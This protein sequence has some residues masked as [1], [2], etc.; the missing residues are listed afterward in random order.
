MLSSPPDKSFTDVPLEAESYNLPDST[1]WVQEVASGKNLDFRGVRL[2]AEQY[3]TNVQ[4]IQQMVDGDKYELRDANGLTTPL[5]ENGR[6]L[7][8]SGCHFE[9]VV[10][11]VSFER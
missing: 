9:A 1:S 3:A 7:W 10:T 5:I 11:K 4:I 8:T 2:L 6:I